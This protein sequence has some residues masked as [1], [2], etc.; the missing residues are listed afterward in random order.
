MV[1]VLFLPAGANGEKVGADD[2]LVEHDRASL[3]ELLKS[4]WT[5]DLAL[6]NH[7]ADIFWHLRDVTPDSPTFDKLIALTS[8]A[9]ILAKMGH[10]EMAAMVER[11]KERY[12]LRAKDVKGLEE[13]IK[14]DYILDIAKT[15]GYN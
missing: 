1:N 10:L 13:D 12:K 8:L 4:A 6:S 9:P 11:L 2:Y 3:A 5:Y 15:H 14:G 7:E